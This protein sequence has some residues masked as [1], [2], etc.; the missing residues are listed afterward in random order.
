MPSGV[1]AERQV[2]GVGLQQVDVA[3]DRVGAD[4]FVGEIVF[5]GVVER[6]QRRGAVAVPIFEASGQVTGL[7][8]S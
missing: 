3:G 8:L 4:D 7:V 1:A 6:Q 2:A 5:N